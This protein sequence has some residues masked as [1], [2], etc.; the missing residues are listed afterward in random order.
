M[1]ISRLT[2]YLKDRLENETI[3]PISGM[4]E[5]SVFYFEMKQS[6]IEVSIDILTIHSDIKT[7][8]IKDFNLFEILKNI[9]LKAKSLGCG[10]IDGGKFIIILS[11]FDP[12]TLKIRQED[13]LFVSNLTSNHKEA[14]YSGDVDSF[15]FTPY[16]FVV[17]EIN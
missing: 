15:E 9:S 5:G 12:I 2:D 16:E 4:F 3:S 7:I 8:A 13:N 10:Y 1:F 17:E 11:F 6:D 14:F